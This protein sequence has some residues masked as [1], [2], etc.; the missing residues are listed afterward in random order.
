M[1]FDRLDDFIYIFNTNFGD[2]LLHHKT[3][4]HRDWFLKWSITL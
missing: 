1:P 3:H 4:L 2:S